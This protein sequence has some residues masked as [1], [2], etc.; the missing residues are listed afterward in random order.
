MVESKL[1]LA[2]IITAIAVNVTIT[3]RQVPHHRLLIQN[4]LQVP[5]TVLI[6]QARKV[7]R[8]VARPVSHQ[9]PVQVP[10]QAPVLAAV[11]VQI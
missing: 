3:H 5:H 11:Q 1:V 7:A 10:R 9:V 6:H 4:L 8:P 2:S